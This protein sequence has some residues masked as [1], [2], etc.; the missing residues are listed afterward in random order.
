MDSALNRNTIREMALHSDAEHF[1]FVDSDTVLPSDALTRLI[2]HG[3][4]IVGGWYPLVHE[5]QRWAVA[6]YEDGVFRNFSAPVPGLVPVD[7]VGLGC[8]LVSRRVY[9]AVSFNP[10]LLPGDTVTLADGRHCPMGICA[11]WGIEARA[12]GF[13]LYADGA[14]VCQHLPRPRA[15]GSAR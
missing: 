15:G 2:S 12:A 7:M 9:E 14:V 13:E 8:A 3:K 11:K 5:S 1:L 10:G 4:D 6:T